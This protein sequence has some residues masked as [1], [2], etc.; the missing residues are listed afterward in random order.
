MRRSLAG[1]CCSRW[2]CACA[3]QAKD[4]QKARWLRN[5]PS[6][7]Q[8]RCAP[9]CKQVI[10][11]KAI[12]ILKA[13]SDRLAAAKSMTFTAVVSYESSSRYGPPLI[14]T[15]KSDVALLRPNKLR[16]VTFGDGPGLGALLQRQDDDGV[17]TSGEPR[18][19][20]QCAAH[21]RRARSKFAF[22]SAAIYYPFTDLIGSDP[23][24]DIADGLEL[25]FY[26]GQ[27]P[28]WAGPGRTWWRT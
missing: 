23:Y 24:K 15:T 1:L 2:Q 28:W 11:P 25:A 12:E 17:R 18:G 8:S 22:D 7:G 26:I 27:S 21:D 13:A 16:V 14:F 6:H 10:E 9:R 19:G 5:L 20:R 3:A 4:A